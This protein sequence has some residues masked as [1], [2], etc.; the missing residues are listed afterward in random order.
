LIRKPVDNIICTKTQFFANQTSAI[1]YLQAMT[2]LN[3][4]KLDSAFIEVI[5][6]VYTTWIVQILRVQI[7]LN[8]VTLS[9][10]SDPLRSL[11]RNTMM[12]L[13]FNYNPPPSILKTV[14]RRH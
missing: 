12:Q 6:E 3:F 13:I 10:N 11:T 1:L 4:K 7:S 2:M 5:D 9:I 14:R 8:A